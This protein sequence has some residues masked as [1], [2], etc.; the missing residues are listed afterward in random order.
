MIGGRFCHCEGFSL[1]WARNNYSFGV[2]L[3]HLNATHS[4]SSCKTEAKSNRSLDITTQID[5]H[6]DVL[7]ILYEMVIDVGNMG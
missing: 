7:T 4:I 6:I 5:T 2:L 1:E 3:L